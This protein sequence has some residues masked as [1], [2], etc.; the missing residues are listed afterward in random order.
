MDRYVSPRL[1]LAILERDGYRCVYCGKTSAD[2]RLEIDHVLAVAR[3]GTSEGTNL[4]AACEDCNRAK[5][6]QSVTPP[7]HVALREAPL[8]AIARPRGANAS[9]WQREADRRWP[10]AMD[11]VEPATMDGRFASVAWCTTLTVHLLRT[12]A[13]GEGAKRIIDGIGCG[14]SCWRDHEVVDLAAPEVI[15]VPAELRRVRRRLQHILGCA[16]CMGTTNGLAPAAAKRRGND[17]IE[18]ML[19]ERWDK[20]RP[21]KH[22]RKPQRELLDEWEEDG[23]VAL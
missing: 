20:V 17:R 12:A 22:R 3:G 6:A 2:A 13:D 18:R 21:V 16:I 19:M 7:E 15:T 14:H 4:V 10:D 5:G 9:V 11:M 8:M 23:L 1:R